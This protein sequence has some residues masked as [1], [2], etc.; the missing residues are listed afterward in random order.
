[1]S[2]PLLARAAA[3]DLPGRAASL[4]YAAG[5]AA[6]RRLPERPGR[7]LFRAGADLATRRNGKGVRRLRGNLARVTGRPPEELDDLVRAAVR[8]YAR[9]WYE[10]FR[11][12]ALSP[13]DVE[14]HFTTPRE[15][16]MWAAQEQ[17]R[18][19][20]FALGHMANWDLAAAWLVGRGRPFTTVAERLEPAALFDRFVAFRE[21]LGMEVLAL[22][23]GERP[24]FEVLAER[25]RAGRLLCL[26]ADRDLSAH[27]VGV[28][29]FGATATMPAGPAALALETGAVLL[30]VTLHFADRAV[31][32]HGTVCDVGEPVPHTDVATMTQQVARHFEQGIA[33]APQDWHMLARLWRDDLDPSA[34]ARGGQSA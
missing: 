7:V 11:L 21:S 28:D 20:V 5:W 12:P 4:G 16:R 14:R 27:G 30:P 6:V 10:V 29:F 33:A 22:T 2:H 8:S 32:P 18:G 1:M 24:P 19:V 9:Y 31:D 13:T 34:A 3:I 17:G 23:G 25:L 15:D 26:L